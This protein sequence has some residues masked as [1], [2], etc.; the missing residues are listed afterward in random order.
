MASEEGL[1]VRRFEWKEMYK[2]LVFTYT[3]HMLDR[4][5]HHCREEIEEIAEVNAEILNPERFTVIH[6]EF[7]PRNLI[8]KDGKIRGVVDWERTIAGDP[9]YGLIRSRESL[10]QKARELGVESPRKEVSKR[11]AEGYTGRPFDR[12]SRQKDNL[13]RMA[14]IAHMM[15]SARDRDPEEVKLEEQL[16]E[17]KEELKD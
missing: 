16:S 17:I 2:S 12:I 3:T 5:Y 9:D 7:S 10:I 4:R 11:L 14:Y 13:Y 1:D 6:Q 8:V 15:W